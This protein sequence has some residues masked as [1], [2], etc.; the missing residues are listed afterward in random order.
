MYYKPERIIRAST[1]FSRRTFTLRCY[2]KDGSMV[3]YRTY[4]LSSEEFKSCLHNT[5]NDW[6]EFL[7]SNDYYE[8]K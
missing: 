6:L 8:V 4:P 1:N 3:K 2:Y 5:N 7:K